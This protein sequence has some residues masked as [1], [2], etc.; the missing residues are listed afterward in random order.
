MT[1]FYNARPARG[2]L[3]LLALCAAALLFQPFTAHAQDYPDEPN[4][5]D[6]T[7]EEAQAY[8]ESEY[9]R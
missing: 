7:A 6:I 5:P 1:T 8:A 2:W 9:G 4:Y 3:A